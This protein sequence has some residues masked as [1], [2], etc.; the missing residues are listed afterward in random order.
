[1]KY[2]SL[3]T[4]IGGFEVAIHIVF[5][6]AECL[7]YSEVK[8]TA[9]KVYEEHY[10]N[11]FNLGDISKITDEEIKELVKDGCD[12]VVGGFPCTNLTSMATIS[13][14]RSGL[15]G[16][17]SGLLY[18]MLRFLRIIKPK[19]FIAENNYSMRKSDRKLITDLFEEIFP[20]VYLTMLDTADFDVQ[21][22]KRL[23]WTNFPIKDYPK[24]CTQIWSDILEPIDECI[25]YVVGDNWI[26]GLNK[27]FNIKTAKSGK[28][29]YR[30]SN[31][32]W[33][34]KEE[35]NHNSKW[36][37]GMISDNMEQQEYKPYPIGKS[38]PILGRTGGSNNLIIDRRVGKGFLIRQLTPIECERLFHL[39]V[40]YTKSAI[41]KTARLDLLG[42]S[43]SNKVVEYILEN[44]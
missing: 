31:T 22:R 12:L 32:T 15:E 41:Y 9:I 5:P 37:T 4:G 6:E 42:N 1:M 28:I 34:F 25:K 19:Y 17:K 39:P 44:L 18:E 33:D 35:S 36:D 30:V 23:F 8:S 40:G 38:R 10:P 24:K 20:E 14:D 3:F 43:V 26:N 7:A 29:A 2:I 16:S 11:H 13:G 27:P 21:T